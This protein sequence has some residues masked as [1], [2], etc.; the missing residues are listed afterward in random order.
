[1]IVVVSGLPRSGT[2]LVMQMLAAGGMR[3]LADDL[4]K[5]DVDNPKGYYE[6]EPVKRLAR[7]PQAI[8]EA[9]GKAVKVISSLLWTL[10][11]DRHYNV[12]LLQRPVE[13]VVASQAAMLQR[14]GAAPPAL[15]GP[16]L[17]AALTAHLKQVE[18]WM[19]KQAHLRVC[20]FSYHSLLRDPQREALNLRAFLGLD[21]DAAAMAAQ[22]APELYRQRRGS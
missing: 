11:A 7:E 22:V 8:A 5:A 18:T 20:S 4:R 17:G 10:P 13:E 21:L 16:A 14:L 1:M 2:S 3:V 6:W 9:E 12:L 19:S 15:S